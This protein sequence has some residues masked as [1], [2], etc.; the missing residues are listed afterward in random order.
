LFEDGLWQ[1]FQLQHCQSRHSIKCY[2]TI[3]HNEHPPSDQLPILLQQRR[4][5]LAY[6]ESS[7]IDIYKSC[8]PSAEPPVTYLE[9]PLHHEEENCPLHI[10]L[11]INNNRPPVCNISHIARVPKEHYLLLFEPSLTTQH[12]SK[13]KVE[14][15]I[16][17]EVWLQPI[18]EQPLSKKKKTEGI[19]VASYCIRTYIYSVNHTLNK[20]YCV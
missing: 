6:L 2:I 7:I 13:G 5:L 16:E 20:K 1:W 10:R 18:D 9:C 17:H 14:L 15:T 19:C 12:F 4:E 8:M 3:H 11:N